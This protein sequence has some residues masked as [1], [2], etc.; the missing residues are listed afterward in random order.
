MSRQPVTHLSARL[1]TPGASA[2]V[3]RALLFGVDIDRD[4]RIDRYIDYFGGGAEHGS[5][6]LPSGDAANAR[7]VGRARR[8]AA[9]T[10]PPSRGGAGTAC[11]Q[12][13]VQ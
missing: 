1:S 5:S 8:E 10:R 9:R 13:K 3:T 2:G 4:K 11:P 12:T 6:S 7:R